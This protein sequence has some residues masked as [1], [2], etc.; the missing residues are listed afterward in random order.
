MYLTLNGDY[1][2][3]HGYVMISDIGSNNDTA[4]ICNTNNVTTHVQNRDWF[5]PDRSAVG[6]QGDGDVAGFVRNKAPMMVRLHR[7]TTT[8]TPFEG[9]YYC[10]VEDDAFT[11]QTVYVGLY[12][13]G[14]GTLGVLL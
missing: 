14:G 1:I 9:I 6:N 5:A 2:P 11:Y 4:L 7:N 13:S 8:G 10:V 12:N 3:N